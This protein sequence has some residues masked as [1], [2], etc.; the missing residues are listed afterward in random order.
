[1]AAQCPRTALLFSC[2]K[3]SPVLATLPRRAF[4]PASVPFP[5][6]HIDTGNNFPEILAFRDA[7][8]R[9]SGFELFV[10]RVPDSIA[11]DCV[12]EV[13]GL[14]ADRNALKKMSRCSTCSLSCASTPHSAAAATKNAPRQGTR[15][16]LPQ[17][18]RPLGPYA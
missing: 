12:I 17:R 1:L 15:F 6:F 18:R 14:R 8:A 4:A 13:S 5:L 7:F 2:S 16:L 3:D 10:R 11:A 9:D